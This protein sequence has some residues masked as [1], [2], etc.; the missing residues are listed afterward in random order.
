MNKNKMAKKLSKKYTVGNFDLRIRRGISG[1]GLFVESP[2]PKGACIIRYTGKVVKVADQENAEGRYLFWTGRGKMINGNVS[3]NKARYINHSCKP[4]CEASGPSGYIFIRTLRKIKAGE[5]INYDY[6]KE[7][8][9]EY[10][11][12]KGCL[13]VKCK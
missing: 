3:T 7:Y 9:D 5:E 1:K 8:F 6:G 13:C 11:K 10:I 4:N 2:I 12:P